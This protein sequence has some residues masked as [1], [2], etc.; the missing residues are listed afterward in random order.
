MHNIGKTILEFGGFY[1]ED[2]P[3][4]R[5]LA[6]HLGDFFKAKA[7]DADLVRFGG[8]SEES[9]I[10]DFE[11]VL[12]NERSLGS[13]LQAML[14]INSDSPCTT[15]DRGGSNNLEGWPASCMA[16][17]VTLANKNPTIEFTVFYKRRYGKLDEGAKAARTKAQ[18]EL[19]KRAPKEE[20]EARA[21]GFRNNAVSAH[22]LGVMR[23]LEEGGGARSQG[24]ITIAPFDPKLTLLAKEYP[25]I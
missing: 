1:G 18:T 24:R 14:I 15:E 12:T 21:E 13:K 6:K 9:M 22:L 2:M 4:G 5:E 7:E 10:R 3:E 23:T 19:G 17:L 11:K 16:K 8:H 20:V 25:N